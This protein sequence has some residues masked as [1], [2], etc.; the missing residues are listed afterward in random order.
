ME[1]INKDVYLYIASYLDDK[2]IISM[3]SVNKKFNDSEIYRQIFS[4]KYPEL[5]QFN[6]SQDDWK[7]FYLDMISYI[8]IL[9]EIFKYD[10]IKDRKYNITKEINPKFIIDEFTL[11]KQNHFI[12]RIEYNFRYP[13]MHVSHMTSNGSQIYY[14]EA[15]NTKFYK[16]LGINIKMVPGYKICSD[17]LTG[18]INLAKLIGNYSII[19][20]WENA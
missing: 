10:Y 18:I 20:L 14:G 1:I 15:P 19:S 3:L 13:I 7:E 4:K 12:N 11:V 8:N 17:N 6:Q 16:N 2:T 5:L 9:K